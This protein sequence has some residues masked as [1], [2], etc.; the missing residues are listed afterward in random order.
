M[1][2]LFKTT[3]LEQYPKNLCSSHVFNAT[4]D[5]NKPQLTQSEPLQRTVEQTT[6]KQFPRLKNSALR[7]TDPNRFELAQRED[8]PA[9]RSPRRNTSRKWRNRREERSHGKQAIGM[10]GYVSGLAFH[11]CPHYIRFEYRGGLVGLQCYSNISKAGD[12]WRNAGTEVNRVG[13]LS[14]MTME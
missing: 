3:L 7:Y 11:Q 8:H 6:R 4:S 9:V 5:R 13:C 12:I 10:L 2:L 1:R 14:G